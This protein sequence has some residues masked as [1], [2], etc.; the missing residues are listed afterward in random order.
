MYPAHITLSC[1]TLL[2]HAC[3]LSPIHTPTSVF[4]ITSWAVEPLL[5]IKQSTSL[6][7]HILPRVLAHSL[8][9]RLHHRRRKGGDGREERRSGLTRV[10]D[11]VLVH[12]DQRGHRLDDGHRAGHH[13]RVVAAPRSERTQGAVILCRLLR[14]RDRRGRLEAD[15]TTQSTSA[16]RHTPFNPHRTQL[17]TRR[18]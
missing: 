2:C 14:L 16:T 4:Y 11:E 9:S 17:R 5:Y 8:R 10:L 13:T 18:T 3:C 1:N 7:Q 12:D 6:L 15:P